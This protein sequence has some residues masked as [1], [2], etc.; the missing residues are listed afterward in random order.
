M[1]IVGCWWFLG[2]P[3][4]GLT[5]VINGRT[6]RKENPCIGLTKV[7]KRYYLK[8]ADALLNVLLRKTIKKP[9]IWPGFNLI[10]F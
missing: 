2:K 6:P 9:G 7:I 3:R 4:R 1:F 8:F 5:V 10:F